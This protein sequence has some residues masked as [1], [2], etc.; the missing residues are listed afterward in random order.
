MSAKR[1]M[2]DAPKRIAGVASHGR[3]ESKEYLAGMLRK[4]RYEP[5]HYDRSE[6]EE[7]DADS[8]ISSVS[9]RTGSQRDYPR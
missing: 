3:A 8:V 2:P 1:K 9:H 4:A 5:G 7:D 6:P